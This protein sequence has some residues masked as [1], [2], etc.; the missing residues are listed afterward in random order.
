V[1]FSA[2]SL[3]KKEGDWARMSVCIGG[4]RD[5]NKR[6]IERD[7]TMKEVVKRHVIPLMHDV[8]NQMMEVT[9]VSEKDKCEEMIWVLHY[10]ARSEEFV[11]DDEAAKEAMK[12]GEV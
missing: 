10:I 7:D 8:K 1:S 5:A 12:E 2:A 9:S 11:D 6:M 3:L 4:M